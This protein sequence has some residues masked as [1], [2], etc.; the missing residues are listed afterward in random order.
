MT[1]ASLDGKKAIVTGGNRGIGKVIAQHL[2]DAGAEVIIC[3]SNEISLKETA[4][5]LGVQWERADFSDVANVKQMAERILKENPEGVDIIVNNAGVS[6][7]GLFVRQ[8][9]ENLAKVMTINF[10]SAVELSRAF[11]PAMMKK[12]AGRIINITSII[13][14]IGNAGQTSYAASK[15]GML[16]F[17]KSLAKEIA[18][19]GITVNAIAPGFIETEMTQKLPEKVVEEYKA[20][21]PLN[22]F[23]QPDD[24]AAAVRFLASDDANYI[25]GTTIHIN[26]G[27]YV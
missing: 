15:A 18:R 6:D 22:R 3:G 16:G 11:V 23:G 26:G 27:L 13:G 9:H 7:D 8:G 14:H 4:L 12:R 20:S 1:F 17:T 25:T 5:E 19:R 24:V 21:I 10:E 2:K